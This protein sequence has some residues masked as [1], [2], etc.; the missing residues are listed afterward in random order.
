MGRNSAQAGARDRRAT[1]DLER[2]ESGPDTNPRDRLAHQIKATREP[3]G[4]P[5]ATQGHVL[6]ASPC[7]RMRNA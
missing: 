6:P 7:G 2:A 4:R 3:R 5:A 1:A